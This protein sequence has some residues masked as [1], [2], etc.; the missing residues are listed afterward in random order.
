MEA[1]APFEPPVRHANLTDILRWFGC[2]A[3]VWNHSDYYSMLGRWRPGV[4]MGKSLLISWAM[5]FFYISTAR[6]ALSSNRHQFSWNKIRR[7][8]F[9][10]TRLIALC[11]LVYEAWRVLDSWVK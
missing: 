5:P 8:V 9:N 11:C 7:R 10:L 3:I 1:Q 4:D 2:F 6:F